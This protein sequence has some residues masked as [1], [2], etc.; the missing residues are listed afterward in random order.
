VKDARQCPLVLLVKAVQ[1]QCREPHET[2]KGKRW[3]VELLECVAEGRGRASGLN[4][5]CVCVCVR[6]V[7]RYDEIFSV[8]GVPPKKH[9]QRGF[10]VPTICFRTEEH[11][12]KP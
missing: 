8:L 2:K 9:V 12:G 3:E 11:R 1:T 10:W 7:E 6:A 4:C 5:V